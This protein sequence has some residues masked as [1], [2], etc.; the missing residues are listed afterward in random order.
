LGRWGKTR[1]GV[2]GA[3]GKGFGDIGGI[4]ILGG[5]LIFLGRPF[6]GWTSTF[7]RLDQKGDL[8]WAKKNFGFT[9][10]FNRVP[11]FFNYKS[12]RGG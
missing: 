5:P 10:T 6:K 7:G 1:T 3:W 8:F 2:L 12:E 11:I 4:L 9:L